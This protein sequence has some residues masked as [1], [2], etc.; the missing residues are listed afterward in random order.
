MITYETL[1]LWA[2]LVFG[3]SSKR[4][5]ELGGKRLHIEEFVRRV[6]RNEVE[7]LTPHEIENVKKIKLSQAEKILEECEDRGQKVIC[8]DRV[9]YPIKLK[10]I[11]DPPLLLF[12][13]GNIDLL[14]CGSAIAVTGARKHS[15]YS[16]RVCEDICCELADQRVTLIT[17]FAGGI[18]RLVNETVLRHG[19]KTVG[20]LATHLDAA[21]SSIDRELCEKLSKNGLVITEHCPALK[22]PNNAV[23]RNRLSVGMSDGVLFIEASMKSHGLNN[24]EHAVRQGKP[25]FVI[26]PGDILDERYF[27][28]RELMRKGAIP[29]FEA[30][31]IIGRLDRRAEYGV[32]QPMGE[33]IRREKEPAK[34][35][36]R[37]KAQ[38]RVQRDRLPVLPQR[39]KPAVIKDPL[40][41]KKPKKPIMQVE[42]Y[43]KLTAA[44]AICKALEG[45]PLIANDIAGVTKLDI[46]TVLSELT[47]LEIRGRVEKLAG[48]Y[49]RLI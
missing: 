35:N 7:G 33:V 4:I 39:I 29:V 44:D 21:G 15:D 25:V 6:A 45:E 22:L 12:Y 31:D 20:V 3:A 26:P 34:T 10:D 32:F 37:S 41:P 14:K 17:G 11:P 2:V 42:D 38:S 24:Q 5:W 1:W 36:R 49:Y 9:E 23:R 40:K 19:G 43:T 16:K 48:G 46:M 13:R 27:G 18:D 47:L 30:E 28:Q 8:I